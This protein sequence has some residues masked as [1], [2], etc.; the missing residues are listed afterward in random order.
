M[1][2][3]WN[4]EIAQPNLVPK[5]FGLLGSCLI[6]HLLSLCLASLFLLQKV[7]RQSWTHP[8]TCEAFGF[9]KNVG[10]SFSPDRLWFC[11]IYVTESYANTLNRLTSLP[12]LSGFVQILATVNQSPV[13]LLGRTQSPS[14]SH[15]LYFLKQIDLVEEESIWKVRY[16][17]VTYNLKFAIQCKIIR[18]LHIQRKKTNLLGLF[19]S[20]PEHDVFTGQ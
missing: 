20:N 12:H 6:L 19:C 3:N 11:I 13:V 17:F 18:I 10:N 7:I 8:T 15:C 4:T 2:T 1:A 16:E 9:Q 5:A 14:S